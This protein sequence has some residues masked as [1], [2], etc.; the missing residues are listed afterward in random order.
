MADNLFFSPFLFLKCPTLELPL[1]NLSLPKGTT[2][3][4]LI[5][6]MYFAMLSGIVYDI[7]HE[8]PSIGVE[9][10]PATG[11]QVP[12]AFVKYKLNNQYIIEGLTAGAVFA[13]GTG[14]FIVLDK[15]TNI[16]IPEKNRFLFS[17]AGVVLVGLSIVLSNVFIRIKMP[18]YMQMIS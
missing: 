3:F 5:I 6:T 8:P 10:D 17:I 15:S 9:I 14:G 16:N 13:M 12:V 4:Y 11:K 1:P 18:Y 2:V 7:I